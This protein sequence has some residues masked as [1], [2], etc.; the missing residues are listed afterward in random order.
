MYAIRVL[1]RHPASSALAIVSLALGIGLNTAVFSVVES[2]LWRSLPFPESER[3]VSVGPVPPSGHQPVQM[4]SRTFL[5]LQDRART[6]DALAAGAIQ[7]VTIVDPGEPS[8]VGCLAVSERFFDVLGA[9]PA[10]GPGFSPADFDAAFAG[11]GSPD[12]PVRTPGAIVLGDT[13][14][15]TRFGSDPAVVGKQIRVT[16]GDRIQVVGVMGPELQSV[17]RAVP[18]QCWFPDVPDAAQGAWR[19][20]IVVGRLAEG[21]SIGE[22]NAELEVIGRSLGEV[23]ASGDRDTLRAVGMVDG[24][25]GQVRT[26]LLF[27]FGAVICVLLVTCA[28]VA[29]LFLAHAAGRR[30]E[31]A[32]R[33][34]LGASRGR[35]VR[36]SLTES[37]VISLVGGLSGF[38]LAIWAVPLLVSLAP[39]DLPR[40]R[41]IGIDWATFAFTLGISVAVGLLCGLLASLPARSSPRTLFGAVQAVTTP[42]AMRIR[43]AVTVCEVALAL[44]LAVAASLMVRTVQALGAI[45]LGFD[46]AGVVAAD[47]RSTGRDFAVTQEF[48][49]AVIERV[50]ALPGVRAA[51]IG[52]GPLFGSMFTGGLV[53]PG[54]KRDFGLVRV[55]A[56]SPGYFE[57]LG[58]SLLAGRFFESRDVVGGGPAVI[59][60]NRT[61]ARTFWGDSDPIGKS[62]LI[63][64]TQEHRVVGVIADIRGSTLEQDPGP[65]IYQ[66]SNRSENFLAG[67]MMIRVDGDPEALVPQIRTIIRSM[68]PETPFSGITPL[69]ARIDQAMAPR[70]FILRVIGLFS[71]LGLLLAVVGVYGVLA[72]FV[73]QRVPE[74]GVRMAFGATARDVL[75]LVIGQGVWLVIVGVAL[76]LTGAVLLRGVMSTLVYGVR[77]LDL[78]AYLTASVLLFT[79]TVAACAVPARRASRLD[80]AVALRSE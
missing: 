43:R 65:A 32:T 31:L 13:L 69:Q 61:A 39:A 75:A 47:L 42:R 38:V 66:L 14:W 10:L 60:V 55:D 16:G 48:H 80:P 5:D 11:R 18:G 53:V 21:R 50:K 36:Q 7:A 54:N 79:A 2:V 41:Q 30:A 62:V 3:L 1:R 78:P 35:L 19:P 57:A 59:L 8:Q 64:K 22:A 34:A 26:Q 12:G 44:M 28:N 70:V 68:S 74:I 63:N 51:G 52:M 33:V 37:L 77:P 56:V 73:V 27:L 23:E 17:G 46:P 67:S 9:K 15:R 45:D 58:A 49:L 20:R 6:F 72:E 40:L 4:L 76:G 71:V 25:V 24:M 29:N